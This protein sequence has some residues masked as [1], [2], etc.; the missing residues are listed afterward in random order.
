MNGGVNMRKIIKVK[1]NPEGTIEAVMF[2]NGETCSIQNA[3]N[4]AKDNQIEG[5]NV[6]MVSGG[7]EILRSNPNNTKDDNLDALPTFE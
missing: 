1:K 4:M 6:S 2:E 7:R 5:V 3:I